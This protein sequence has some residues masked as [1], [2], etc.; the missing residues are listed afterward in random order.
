VVGYV[1]GAAG[2]VTNSWA[3]QWEQY[4]EWATACWQ[5]QVDQVL[6]EMREWAVRVGMP[7]ADAADDDPRQLLARAIT[8]LQNNRERMNYPE[9]RRQGLPVT[10]SLVESL[11]KEFNL[12]VKGTEKFWNRPDHGESILQ[13]R[14]ALLSDGDRLHKYMRNRP[15]LTLCSTSAKGG[16]FCALNNKSCYGPVR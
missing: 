6:E 13:V 11:I 5:G 15:R 7:P 14:A 4:H 8:Y 12:R 1:Y 9:Y 10:S 3:A 2:A 16:M